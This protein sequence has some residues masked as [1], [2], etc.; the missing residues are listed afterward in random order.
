MSAQQPPV[1]T[2]PALN[3]RQRAVL[4][5]VAAGRATLSLSCEPDLFVDGLCCCD[6]SC[7]HAMVRDGLIR[8]SRPGRIGER[9]PALLTAQAQAMLGE[10]AGAA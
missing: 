6:Q 4:R 5:A 9:V 7:V 10:L 3:G 8:P 2:I 1:L